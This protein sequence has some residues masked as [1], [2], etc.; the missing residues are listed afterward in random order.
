MEPKPLSAR[1]PDPIRR[2][3]LRNDWHE[4]TFLHW[5]YEPSV[6][7]ALLPDGLTV[8]TVDGRAWVSLVPFHMRRAG[9]SRLPPIPYVSGFWE[10]N[11]RTYVVDSLGNRAVWFLSLDCARLPVVAFARWTIGF[12]YFWARMD[13]RV[14][15]SRRTYRTRRRRW[16]RR[17][18]ATTSVVVDVGDEIEPD[19]LDVFL[20]AR[21]GTVARSFGRLWFHAVDHEPWT[22][23][24]ATVVDL[25]DS[26]VAA[27]GLPAPV[28]DPIVRWAQPVHA[29]FARPVRV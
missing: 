10:T 23:H 26:A 21:W 9:P 17:P 14:D 29:R 27:A 20:S 6:V 24:D 3:W 22:F 8:D 16:P 1:C 4:L 11:V 25:D 12:P 28:G 2:G 19:D 13:L 5:S 7:Q 18:A 15:G